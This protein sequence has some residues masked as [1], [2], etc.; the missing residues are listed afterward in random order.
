MTELS[1]NKLKNSTID[2][3][4]EFLKKEYTN[5]FKNYNYIFKTY[6]E[7]LT[8]IKNILVEIVNNMPN[9]SSFNYK[10]Y[11][12]NQSKISLNNYVRQLLDG[13]DKIAILSSYISMNID[14]SQKALNELKKLI[15]WMQKINYIPDPSIIIEL[16]TNNLKLKT[17][18]NNII[19]QNLEKI[20]KYGLDSIFSE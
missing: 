11:I 3:I 9:K 14:E 4:C 15:S 18:L 17:I 1:Y 20:Q 12:L 2:E 10:N 16:V 13:E 19:N 7:F 8:V 6:N 5:I